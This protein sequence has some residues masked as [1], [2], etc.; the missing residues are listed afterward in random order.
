MSYNARLRATQKRVWAARL[1]ND[2]RAQDAQHKKGEK[3]QGWEV[4]S[5]QASTIGIPYH[6]VRKVRERTNT[7]V[8]ETLP[9]GYPILADTRCLIVTRNTL[10]GVGRYRSQFNTDA[11]S[12]SR[13]GIKR[14]HYYL[15]EHNEPGPLDTPNGPCRVCLGQDP[16]CD[17][18]P[19]AFCSIQDAGTMLAWFTNVTPLP[20]P[21]SQ[22][23]GLRR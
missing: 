10:S 20:P 18:P 7:K 23:N 3:I 5:S 9:H 22:L 17:S 14:V 15:G 1:D 11:A 6:L 21:R 19:C 13:D 16:G 12:Q 4:G 8:L 2:P